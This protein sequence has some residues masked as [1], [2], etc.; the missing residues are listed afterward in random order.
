MLKQAFFPL[1]AG[2]IN[3]LNIL[4]HL[5][6]F[7]FWKAKY[8]CPLEGFLIWPTIVGNQ[9]YSLT[10]L[11]SDLRFSGVSS[12]HLRDSK[13][14]YKLM[15]EEI[16]W[17]PHSTVVPGSVCGSWLE[18]DSSINSWASSVSWDWCYSS[19]LPGRSSQKPSLVPSSSKDTTAFVFLEASARVW[20]TL[21]HV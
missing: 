1:W 20:Q 11:W 21:F 10:V 14:R 7:H 9:V 2:K 13:P 8:L 17:L 15:I 18:G 5:L 4:W 19:P 6:F 3:V 16:S 12:F